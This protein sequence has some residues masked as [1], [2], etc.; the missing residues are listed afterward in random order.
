MLGTRGLTNAAPRPAPAAPGSSVV[1]GGALLTVEGVPAPLWI[2]PARD[3]GADALRMR[4]DGIDVSI[5]IRTPDG[6]PVRRG[7]AGCLV[8]P[9]PPAPTAPGQPV[10]AV[11]FVSG[12]GLDAR[13][14]MHAWIRGS[15]YLGALPGDVSGRFGGT[16]AI[17]GAL[18]DGPAVLR[19]CGRGAD[20]WTRVLN[21]GVTVSGSAA[22]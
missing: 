14:S 4:G 17:P 12:H 1:L 7:P 5:S 11:A 15:V 20:G 21:I 10:A 18:V 19:L 2:A 9:S 6:H 22:P 16:L 13:S 3:D 8:L